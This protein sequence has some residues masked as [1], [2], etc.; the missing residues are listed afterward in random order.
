MGKAKTKKSVLKRI[1]ITGKKKFLR[2]I[3]G[4]NHF[5]S[6]KSSKKI[7]IKRK[8]KIIKRDTN[9]KKIISA[10]PYI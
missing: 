1:K 10:I 9:K 7:R 8:K 6:K 3:S 2:R 5:K 4:Q